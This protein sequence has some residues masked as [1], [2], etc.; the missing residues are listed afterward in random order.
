MFNRMPVRPVKI[1]E[2]SRCP[3]E[4]TCVWRG[5]LRIEVTIGGTR[6]PR[7]LFL[8]DGKAVPFA[9]GSLMLVGTRPAK[10]ADGPPP[11]N[12]ILRYD[13]R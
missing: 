9:G 5:R 2:D 7:T 6:S 1:L 11:R 13:R 12:F 3:I 10:R 8:E 4:V